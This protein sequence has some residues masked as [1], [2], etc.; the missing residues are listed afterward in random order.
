ML[1]GM[2]RALKL[3]SVGMSTSLPFKLHS[4]HCLIRHCRAGRG[5]P[6]QGS[7]GRESDISKA[8]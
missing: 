6:R 8:L 1:G 3:R 4:L 2:Q 7:D 5:E